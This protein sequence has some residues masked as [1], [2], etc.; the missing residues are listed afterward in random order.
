MNKREQLNINKKHEAKGVEFVDID[1]VYI[2]KNVKIGKGTKLY[3][4]VVLEGNTVLGENCSIGM[5]S[6]I[7]DSC[8]GDRV[9]IDH[10][11][12][13]E[14]RIGGDTSIG[15]FAYLRPGS[16]IGES[17]KIGDFVEIKNS[18]IGDGSKSSHLA[19]D[20]SEERRVGK[21]CRSRW[22]PYH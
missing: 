16:D 9:S 22:S 20:R 10:S 8:V 1:T 12:V 2:D 17:C 6:H 21:E 14:S 15:P 3:P 19:D 13:K 7:K 11:V 5:G 18:T 4:S